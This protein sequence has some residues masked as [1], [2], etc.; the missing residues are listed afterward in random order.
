[1]H[2]A[3]MLQIVLFALW[4][5]WQLVCGEVAFVGFAIGTILSGSR[6][7]DA[8]FAGCVVGA[9]AG[10]L[11][12]VFAGSWFLFLLL[13]AG[14]L[15]PIAMAL[16]PASMLAAVLAPTARAVGHARARMLEG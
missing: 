7:Y 16:A 11:G 15:S 4:Q 12:G 6:V 14:T 2:G 9:A 1:M 8:S 13:W 10:V 3:A 5:Q